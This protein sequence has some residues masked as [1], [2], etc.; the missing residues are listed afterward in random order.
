VSAERSARPR[1]RRTLDVRRQ[2]AAAAGWLRARRW[3]RL[4]AA[5]PL[6]A[7]ALGG[8]LAVGLL[9]RQDA[10][11]GPLTVRLA[12]WPSLH[13]GSTL[14]VPPFGTVTADTHDGLLAVRATLDNVDARALARLIRRHTRPTTLDEL[15]TALA[16]LEHQAKVVTAEFL[17]RL[18][19][20][21]VLGGAAATLVLPRRS[22]R[23]AG[24]C[25]LGGLLAILVL[26]VPTLVT[27]DLGA[28]QTPEFTGTLEYAPALIGDVR[29]LP[30][31][32]DTL[33]R[34][35]A[36]IATNLDRAY[37]ALGQ[38]PPQLDAGTVRLLHVSD[39]H[40][41]PA[42][43]DLAERLAAQFQVD[44]VVDTGDMGTWGLPFERAVPHR[45]AAFHVPYLFVKGNHDSDL[46]VKAV[47][48]S[49]A[50]VLDHQAADVAGIRFYGVGDPTFS[51]GQGYRTDELEALKRRRSVQVAGELDRLDPPAD[52]LLVHDPALAAYAM[53]HVATVLDGHLHRFGTRVDHGTRELTDATT[54]AAGPD[55]L[56]QAN[57]PPYG[58]EVVYLDAATRRP[59][60]IDQITVRSLEAEFSVHRLVLPEG[61]AG[62]TPSP[63]PVPAPDAPQPGDETTVIEPPSTQDQPG[64]RRG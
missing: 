56:R 22:L 35:M 53:G 38:P 44:A 6:L 42:G 45:V 5:A 28:F 51:P 31:R 7:G 29:T 8:A 10:R 18:L 48:A 4:L 23:R 27:F 13:A 61:T 41:N 58:A 11:I 20:V 21:G 37:A 33:R 49:G 46:M 9:A 50:R 12:A 25:A 1:E 30:T 47:A 40:L 52:V 3:H 2:A 43:F 57:P 14:A 16:P 39:L 34:E 63:V 19:A 64:A 36:R 54:G 62:F 15:A 32:L 59:I 24:W 60:A 17:L 55:G 26:L